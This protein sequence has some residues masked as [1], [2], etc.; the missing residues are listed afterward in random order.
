MYD[1]DVRVY[2]SMYARSVCFKLV[3]VEYMYVCMRL[4]YVCMYLCMYVCNVCF[5]VHV[6]LFC[7]H[8]C[9]RELLY[10]MRARM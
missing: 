8:V 2:V 3:H 10:V 4:F 6:C 9:A 1:G 5:A 7:M